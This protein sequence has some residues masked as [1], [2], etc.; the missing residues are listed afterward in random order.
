MSAEGPCLIDFQGA[1]P[2]PLAYDAA[3]LILDPYAGHPAAIR[4]RLLSEYLRLLGERGG[5]DPRE[6]EESWLPLGAFRLLQA[7]GAFGKLG[8]RLG[9]PGFL[10]HAGKALDLLVEHLGPRGAARCP[11]LR[12]LVGRARDRWRESGPAIQA[13]TR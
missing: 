2:G 12:A 6:V 13:T 7:L 1:R 9:K 11:I 4:E 3:A 8:V 5:I 10:E